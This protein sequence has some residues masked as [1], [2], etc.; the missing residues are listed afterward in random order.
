[1]NTLTDP[2]WR[3]P[4]VDHPNRNDDQSNT[5]AWRLAGA[6]I[7]VPMAPNISIIVLAHDFRR[8]YSCCVTYWYPTLVTRHRTPFSLPM[9]AQ[10]PSTRWPCDCS[11]YC[12][13]G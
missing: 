3:E 5:S 11:S 10:A 2:P 1:M 13:L 9:P 8:A 7:G 4:I 6:G 12:V